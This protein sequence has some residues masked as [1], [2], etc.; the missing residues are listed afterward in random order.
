VHGVSDCARLLIRKPFARR[1]CCFPANRTA[2]A[3]RNSTRFAAQYPA[4]GLPCERFKLNL[5]ASPCIT[6]GRGGWLGL[7][8]WKTCTSYP[9]PAFLALSGSGQSRREDFV[10]CGGEAAM[11]KQKRDAKC[12]RH[13]WCSALTKVRT[14][15]P[16]RGRRPSPPPRLDSCSASLEANVSNASGGE[17]SAHHVGCRL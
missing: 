9:L 13:T 5:A 3:P 1:G 15:H 8:P 6:R 16:R 10:R 7:T 2:S 14:L 17:A 12:Q 11:A 4:R